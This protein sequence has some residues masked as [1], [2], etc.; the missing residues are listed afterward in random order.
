MFKQGLCVGLLM[1]Y[2]VLLYAQSPAL[3]DPTQPPFHGQSMHISSGGLGVKMIR[4]GKKEKFAMINDRTLKEGDT[5]YGYRVVKIDKN[6]VRLQGP[7][8]MLKL[9]L[10]N[11]I[12]KKPSTSDCC[13]EGK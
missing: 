10:L 13:K 1:T 6:T 5:I 4:I 7:Q 9:Q 12:V 8:G 3:R 2:S 11:E